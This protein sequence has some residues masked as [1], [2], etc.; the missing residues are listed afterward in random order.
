MI[1]ETSSRTKLNYTYS[2]YNL[3]K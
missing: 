2:F 3:E 1:N